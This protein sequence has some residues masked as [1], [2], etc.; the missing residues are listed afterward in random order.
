MGR[1]QKRPSLRRWILLAAAALALVAFVLPPLVNLS[2]YQHRIAESIGRSI[3]RPVHISSVKLRLLP[4]PG[5]EFSDFS[6]QEDPQFGAEPVLHSSSV[7]AYLRILSL[8]RGRLEVSRI[9]FDDASL[10]L[11]RESNGGWNVA[12]MLVQAAQIPNAPTG[13]RYAGSAP[14]FPYIEAENARI[15]FKQG[16]EK[17]PLSFLNSDLSISLNSSND[18][19]LHFRAQPVRTDLNLSLGDT[20]TLRIDGMLHRAR[21]LGEMPLKL[22]LDWTGAPLG[23]LSRLMLGR[24]FD[25]RG[26]LDVQSELSGTAN[27]AQ[28]SARLKIAGFHRSE[29]SA[30][31]PLDVA[32]S[33]RA[34]FRKEARSLDEVSCGS[35]IGDGALSL[36]G[37]VQEVLTEPQAN[38]RLA[39]H[40][41]PAAAVLSG[42]QQVRSSLAAGAQAT[43]VVNGDFYY[44]SQSR[45]PPQIT[46]QVALDSLSLSP[47]DS[48]KPFVLAPVRLRCSS[49]EAGDGG[50]PAL[51]LQPVRLA[52]GAP[53]PVTLD[54]RFTPTGFDLHLGGMSSLNRLQAFNRA[55]GLLNLARVALAGPGT[56]ALNLDVRGRWLLPVPDPDHPMATS[57][58]EGSIGIRNAE[59]STS[60]L[61]QPLRIVSAQ[62]ILSA[63]QT[64][65]TNATISYG[66]LEGQGSLEYPTLCIANAPCVGHF[67][68]NSPTLDLGALQTTLLGA[69]AGGQLL[70]ELLDR[71]DRH[72]AKWPELSGTVQIG[73]LS[74]GKLVVHDAIGAVDIGASLIK[75][76][77]L[78]GHVASGTLRLAGAVD[79]SG[80][81]PEYSFDVQVTNA[82]PSALAALFEE[83]WGSGVANF[84]GQVRLSGFDAE[85]LARSA[86][87]TLRWNWNKGGLAAGQEA[88]PVAAEPFVHFDQWSAD[89]VIADSTIKI[90]HSLLARGSDA[91]P[92]SGT[93]SF[94]RELDLKGGAAP[95]TVAITGTLEHPEVKPAGEQ[96]EN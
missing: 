14:R 62:G 58:A 9:H 71:I 80:S 17:M 34:L 77:S 94:D 65:W 4:L 76:R 55:F 87:G 47:P 22:K 75:I 50:Y 32:A 7:V 79:A 51:L 21:L 66:K 11:V 12:S 60:Y 41:V 42:L 46:G 2:H 44:A 6:V 54:G 73:T 36:T 57:T 38:L 91:I 72:P 86:T 10:N 35:V 78:N 5:F 27:Q 31:H 56:A 28:I 40:S 15:N 33:C 63:G 30:T 39:I 68:L 82:A 3:G 64:A 24:D 61:S 45:H 18:W 95:D 70:R 74:T 69:S 13:Q 84:S 59:L 37:V 26:D 90:T 16:N 20:G 49:P 92:L 85:E 83:R 8:W 93:I 88:L 53:A 43:G 89:A 52:M 48:S 67:S 19:E 25:W 96:V 81:E 29:F 1:E 23:Q